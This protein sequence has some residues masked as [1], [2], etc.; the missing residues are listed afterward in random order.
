M[1]KYLA[2]ISFVL[3]YNPLFSEREEEVFK[4]NVIEFGEIWNLIYENSHSLK[5]GSHEEKSSE[6]AKNRAGKHWIPRVYSDVRSYNT[7]DPAMNFF[8]TLGQRSATDADF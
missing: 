4:G 3:L 6:I 5:A 8:S 7:N 1:K 2:L